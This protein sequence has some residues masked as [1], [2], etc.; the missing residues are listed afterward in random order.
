MKKKLT[1][2]L[3]GALVL[4]LAASS[5]VMAEGAKRIFMSAAYYTA[6]YGSPLM[7]AVENRAKELGYEIQIVDGE[8]NA[9]KQLT[10]LKTAVADGFDALIYWP[11]DAASTPPVVD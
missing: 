6:P 7:A 1:L 4:S 5:A 2:I 11:G 8:E 9:D 3:A 10:Q